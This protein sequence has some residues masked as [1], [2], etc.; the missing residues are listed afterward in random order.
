MNQSRHH[1]KKHAKQSVNI[2][3]LISKG[4][5]YVKGWALPQELWTSIVDKIIRNG[6]DIS[7]GYFPG[8]VT[9]V[10]TILDLNPSDMEETP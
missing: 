4:R 1:S 9:D 10:A 2:E 6:G 7:T 3:G 5:T 8:Q